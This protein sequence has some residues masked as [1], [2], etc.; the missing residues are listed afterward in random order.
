M[1]DAGGRVVQRHGD[2]ME[3]LGE[4]LYVGVRQRELRVLRDKGEKPRIELELRCL[5]GDGGELE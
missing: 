4:G 3:T 5:G 1:A 2:I